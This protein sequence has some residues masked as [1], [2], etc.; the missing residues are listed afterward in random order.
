[1]RHRTLLATVSWSHDLLSENE[2]TVVAIALRF[3]SIR[4][5]SWTRVAIVPE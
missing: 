5:A 2:K 3:F 1:M 4:S